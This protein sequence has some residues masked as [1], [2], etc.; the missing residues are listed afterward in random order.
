[1]FLSLSYIIGQFT[2]LSKL[3]IKKIEQ[4]LKAVSFTAEYKFAML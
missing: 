3:I 1:M 2:L 4:K